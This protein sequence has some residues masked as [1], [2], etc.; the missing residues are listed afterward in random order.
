M[1][2]VVCIEKEQL[3]AKTT[4]LFLMAGQGKETTPVDS[5]KSIRHCLETLIYE[6]RAIGRISV[7]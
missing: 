1:C 6:G 2:A 7:V 5:F 4:A 3:S